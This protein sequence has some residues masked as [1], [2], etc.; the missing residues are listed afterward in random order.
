VRA[1]I[2]PAYL[3]AMT[4]AVPSRLLKKLDKKPELAEGWTWATDGE[5][6]TVTTDK[7]VVVTIRGELVASDEDLEC[8]C[9]LAPKC[10]HRLAVATRL[11]LADAEV[12]GEVVAEE[13]AIEGKPV[14]EEERVAA[15]RGAEALGELCLSGTRGGG[16][17]VQAGMLRAIHEARALGLH[18][19]AAALLTA[20]QQVRAQREEEEV[21]DAAILATCA[22][23]L[24][25]CFSLGDAEEATILERGVGRR[26]YAELAPTKLWGIA[27]APIATRTGLSGLVTWVVD[28][29]GA[30]HSV[31]TVRPGDAK[32]GAADTAAFAQASISH[33]TLSRS[34]VILQGGSRS[35]D[36]RLGAG[37]KVRIA[38]SGASSLFDGPPARLFARPLEAQLAH[39]FE[40]RS[41]APLL[42]EAGWDLLTVDAVL[43]GDA[44]VLGERAARLVLRTGATS[45]ERAA[46]TAMKEAAGKR[47]RLVARL[48]LGRERCVEPLAIAVEGATPERWDLGFSDAQHT[49][50]ARL[51]DL[52]AAAP[53]REV[54]AVVPAEPRRHPWTS[55]ERVTHQVL[56]G[57]WRALPA[58]REKELR[59]E[60]ARLRGLGL[61]HGADLLESLRVAGLASGRHHSGR[62]VP[63][64]REP[65][66]AALAACG[67]YL[68]ELDAAR[69][70]R[71]WR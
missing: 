8:G 47:V 2:D 3:A 33:R 16:A 65:Y 52:L 14:S 50:P 20:L 37:K 15:R 67:L 60:Q 6:T 19:I 30:L 10:L 49:K 45:K 66:A 69:V 18:R 35:F 13:P 11:P 40:Q 27:S 61:V 29:E 62:L 32:G 25:L 42:R 57:G 46:L 7:D 54:A 44:V 38:E 12:S 59:Q 5:A 51:Q 9:L 43:A 17:V 31:S 58:E 41:R 56:R 36:R 71:S 48:V 26:S 4:G 64:A 68:G 34:E 22:E 21:P 23:A 53:E 55:L 63:P 39:A 28:R 1:R 24:A 70:R